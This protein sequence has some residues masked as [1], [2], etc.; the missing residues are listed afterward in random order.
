M[1]AQQLAEA[2]KIVITLE[3][4]QRR[5]RPS[6][7]RTMHAAALQPG[8]QTL[9]I[10]VAIPSCLHANVPE[11]SARAFTSTTLHM[12][13][14]YSPSISQKP[15]ICTRRGKATPDAFQT[16]GPASVLKGCSSG[17]GRF[18]QIIIDLIHRGFS[19]TLY[20]RQVHTV[21]LVLIAALSVLIL[22]M[23]WHCPHIFRTVLNGTAGDS[24]CLSV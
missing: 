15:H 17:D 11:S 24:V 8:T 5:K 16:S 10:R 2:V 4:T 1:E 6:N 23:R 14:Q 20:S 21:Q 19:H 22:S 18:H 7:K 3:Y 13:R 12:S 9:S